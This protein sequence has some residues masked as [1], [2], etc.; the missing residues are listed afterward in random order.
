MSAVAKQLFID[1]SRCQGHA[2]CWAFAPEA[3]GIDDEGYSYVLPGA[4]GQVD[5]ENVRKAMKNCPE[6][7]ILVV[8]TDAP[9]GAS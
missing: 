6:R 2:R 3:F 9:E 8:D 7:A 5:A 1:L 4:E